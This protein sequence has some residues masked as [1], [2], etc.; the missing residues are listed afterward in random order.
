MKDETEVKIK[1]D[2]EKTKSKGKP[3]SQQKS[4]TDEKPES[5]E[6]LDTT[7]KPQS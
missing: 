7:E 1:P 6:K 2:A 3:D 4:E 5:V